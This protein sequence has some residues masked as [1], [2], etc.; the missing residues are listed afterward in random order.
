MGVRVLLLVFFFELPRS[1][2]SAIV[3]AK[4]EIMAIRFARPQIREEVSL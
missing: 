1:I 2:L 4:S 3:K